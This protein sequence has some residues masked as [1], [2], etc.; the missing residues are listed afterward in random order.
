MIF[1]L[2][3]HKITL[4]SGGTMFAFFVWS[5]IFLSFLSKVVKY[6][7]TYIFIKIK[8]DLDIDLRDA[9]VNKI[10]LFDYETIEKQRPNTIMQNIDYGLKKFFALL[11]LFLIQFLFEFFAIVFSLVFVAVMFDVIVGVITLPFVI[12]YFW[13]TAIYTTKMQKNEQ[14]LNP[15]LGQS[16]SSFYSLFALFDFIKC[17]AQEH[18]EKNKYLEIGKKVNTHTITS[19]KYDN[20][21]YIMQILLTVT[22]IL[23]IVIYYLFLVEAG[24]IT[25]GAVVATLM[26]ISIIYGAINYFCYIYYSSKTNMVAV[27]ILVE[28]LSK[29]KHL[30]SDSPNAR[31][32]KKVKGQIEFKNVGF[33][34]QE[35]CPLK[36]INL[37]ILPNQCVALVGGRGSGKSTAL[38]LLLRL[39]EV[40]EGGVF[41]DDVNIKNILLSSLRKNIAYIPQDPQVFYGTFYEN[42]SYGLNVSKEEIIKATKIFGLHDTIMLF[43]KGYDS[44][45]GKG[46]V[47]LEPAERQRI[48]IVRARLRNAPILL[49]DSLILQLGGEN[50][51][52]IQKLMKKIVKGKTALLVARKLPDFV[53]K[54]VDKVIVIHRDELLEGVRQD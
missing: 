17:F 14:K 51:K 32:L 52:D 11:D 35:S 5:Y 20:L 47:I 27:T 21:L 15:I 39:Y 36:R 42:I 49:M 30:I 40:D 6:Y 19:A 12:L 46:G 37:K 29:A 10:F 44:F 7:S 24:E 33:C 13:V 48:A 34:Y 23:L 41:I 9:A 8:S 1:D 43:P 54:L 45:V 3:Q 26:Y 38:K 25:A 16:A 18:N 50:D 28:F 31:E 4:A 2:S 53:A 22:N